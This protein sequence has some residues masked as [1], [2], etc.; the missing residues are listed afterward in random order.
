[1]DSPARPWPSKVNVLI[2]HFA[3]NMS[4]WMEAVD[5]IITKAG[6]GTI[7][8][9]AI[10]RLP[11]MLSSCLPGQEEGNV[12]FVVNGGFGDFSTSPK[13]I[14]RTVI[15]W[16]QDD[17]KLKEMSRNAYKAAKP[18]ATIDICKEIGLMIF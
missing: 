14:V 8:E 13:V 4:E 17:C 3:D 1:M 7:A 18:N 15:S 9:C 5:C 2:K 16:F 12:S 10:Q 6:P 11:I